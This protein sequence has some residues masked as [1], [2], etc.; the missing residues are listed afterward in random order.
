MPP[1]RHTSDRRHT[2]DGR[3]E[4]AEAGPAS[5]TTD[6]YS[7]RP[8]EARRPD[9]GDAR[10]VLLRPIALSRRTD[11]ARL[12]RLAPR[13]HEAQTHLALVAGQARDARQALLV[14]GEALV[15]EKAW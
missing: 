3:T 4:P 10:A 7:G 9:D 15:G 5:E 13:A 14:P 1:A 2:A 6:R 12:A 11:R 8:G